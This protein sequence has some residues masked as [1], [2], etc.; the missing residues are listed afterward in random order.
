M[1]KCPDLSLYVIIDAGYLEKIHRNFRQVLIPALRAGATAIQLR[2]KGAGFRMFLSLAKKIRKVTS[3]FRVPFIINDSP[4]IARLSGAD[5][6][7]VGYSDMPPDE[8]RACA[9]PG[10][11]IGVSASDYGQAESARSSGADYIGLGPVFETPTKISIPV[12]RPVLLRVLKGIKTPIVAIGGIKEYNIP[13]LKKSGIRNFCF[14][15]E[16]SGAG[17]VYAKVKTLKE[18]IDDPA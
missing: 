13:D 16:V 4:S 18:I 2:A 15:S 9:G 17:D 12:R 11:I 5:G 3:K 14:I 8:A 1:K 7:H 10:A 6:V